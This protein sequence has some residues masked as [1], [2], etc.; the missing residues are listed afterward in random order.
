MK[1]YFG[2]KKCFKC[3]IPKRIRGKI[4]AFYHQKIRKKINRD[5]LMR[6]DIC[7]EKVGLEIGPS[8][9]PIVS[10]KD[11]YC[12]EIVDWLDQKGLQEH[13]KGHGVNL[14]AI[15]EVDYVWDGGSYYDLIGKALYYDYIVASH[16]IEHTTNFLRFLQDCSKLLKEDGFLRL[17]VPDKRFCFDHF[18]DVTGIAEVLNDYY[19]PNKMHSVGKVAEYHM[20]VVKYKNRISWDKHLGKFGTWK[21]SNSN[22]MF[23]HSLEEVK[24]NM[25]KVHENKE[26]IDIHHYVFTPS[27]FQL[28]VE[29][30]R[31]LNLIDM[32]IIGKSIA[33]GNEFIITMQKTQNS[34]MIDNESRKA[35]IRKRN[36]ENKI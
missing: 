22:Y 27:S 12:V 32:R 29:E 18:R 31:L 2:L 21:C 23:V 15:E 9:H 19:A 34:N 8:H 14:D 30:L 6:E 28:L 36:R 20:N 5:E 11:G 16:M 13:Y 7:K 35:L 26:Y 24:E 10:K 3:L 1:L 4:V 25:L 33:Y 17:A